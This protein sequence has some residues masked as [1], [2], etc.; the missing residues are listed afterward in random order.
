ME[1]GYNN[2]ELNLEP[3]GAGPKQRHQ[4]V[5]NNLCACDTEVFGWGFGGLGMCRGAGISRCFFSGAFSG[6]GGEGG[7]VGPRIRAT[8]IGSNPAIQGFLLKSRV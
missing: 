3:S 5:K 7:R 6:T 1:L 8:G 2:L 4:E